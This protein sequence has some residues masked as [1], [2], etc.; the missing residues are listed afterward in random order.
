M[1]KKLLLYATFIITLVAFS[2]PLS[3][4]KVPE[5]TAERFKL[6]K[7]V[8][9]LQN[10]PRKALDTRDKLPLTHQDYMEAAGIS[11]SDYDSVEWTI[12]AESGW[13]TY[14]RGAETPLGSACGIQQE[15]PC[16]K[17]GCSVEDWVCLLKWSDRYVKDRYGSWGNEVQFHKNNNWY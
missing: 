12:N 5:H 6:V 4:A 10:S 14:A 17:S 7:P 11:P 1:K 3:I 8:A 15:L 2:L 13:N 16:G 9:G